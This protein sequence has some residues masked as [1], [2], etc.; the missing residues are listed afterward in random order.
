[1][2]GG[3]KVTRLLQ[4]AHRISK[5]AVPPWSVFF[6]GDELASA[7]K[8]KKRKR[9]PTKAEKADEEVKV[10][11]REEQQKWDA[12][13]PRKTWCHPMETAAV[14]TRSFKERIVVS[15]IYVTLSDL[16]DLGV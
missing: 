9:R 10:E 15:T 2:R 13:S 12:Q 6:S 8:E 4:R 7:E 14:L 1:M 11:K 5:R 3:L 16:S